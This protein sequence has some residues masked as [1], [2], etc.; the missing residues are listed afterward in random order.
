SEGV[1]HTR[2]RKERKYG[3]EEFDREEQQTAQDGEAVRQPACKVESDRARQEAA[4]GRSFCRVAE[5][6][7]V[8]AQ[9]FQDAYPQ[10][11]RVEWSSARLLPQASLEPYRIARAWVEGPDPRP[12]EVEL[13]G[14][15]DGSQRSDRRHDRAYP[16][17]ADAQQVQGFDARFEAA[18]AR[19]RGAQD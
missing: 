12:C 18:R 8:A 5:A 13:V 14:G 3:E 4:D 6:G 2:N 7:G 11:L 9:L 16:Q 17:R 10:P 19:A 1:P 15:R